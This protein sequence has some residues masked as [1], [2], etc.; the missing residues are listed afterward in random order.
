MQVLKFTEEIIGQL[1]YYVYALIDPRE[2]KVFYVGKGKG[3]RVFDHVKCALSSPVVSDKLD[4]IRSLNGE[5]EHI[6]VRSGLTEHEAFE[7]EAALIDL[8]SH[9]VAAPF[10]H[11][12][13]VQSGHHTWAHGLRT[14]E[15]ICNAYHKR[16]DKDVQLLQG[17][18]VLIISLNKTFGGARSLYDTVRGYW[19]L[20]PCH[21]QKCSYVLAEY[22]GYVVGVFEVTGGW[23]VAPNTSPV[24]YFFEGREIHAEEAARFLW[25]RL[26]VRPRGGQNPIRYLKN[27]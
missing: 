26:P 18:E 8:L 13:N 19:V 24:R 9:D 20:S 6:I 4:Y 7:V 17:E 1:K 16:I 14:V 21:A 11:I 25:H 3:N 27:I 2:R 5:V 15:E 23:H 12:T 10:T 22:D